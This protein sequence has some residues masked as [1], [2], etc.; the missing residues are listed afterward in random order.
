M[1][2]RQKVLV[3][4]FLVFS[5]I[6]AFEQHRLQRSVQPVTHLRVRQLFDRPFDLVVKDGLLGPICLRVE[7]LLGQ[8]IEQRVL[9]LELLFRLALLLFFESLLL[10]LSVQP[11]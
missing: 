11:E 6:I 9:P 8:V 3:H 2:Q 4:L 7:T 1:Q 10:G 5:V